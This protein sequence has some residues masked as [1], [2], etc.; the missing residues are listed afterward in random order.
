L[1][2]NQG[3]LDAAADQPQSFKTHLVWLIK[4]EELASPSSGRFRVVHSNSLNKSRL[5]IVPRLPD[6]YFEIP[7]EDPLAQPR[8]FMGQFLILFLAEIH[9][10]FFTYKCLYEARKLHRPIINPDTGA[11]SSVSFA[12]GPVVHFPQ[13]ALFGNDSQTQ[14]LVIKRGD[15][16]A[17]KQHGA[18]NCPSTEDGQDPIDYTRSFGWLGHASEGWIPKFTMCASF[19][20]GRSVCD[21]L[22]ETGMVPGTK[23]CSPHDTVLHLVLY[24]PDCT[25][26]QSKTMPFETYYHEYMFNHLVFLLTLELFQSSWEDPSPEFGHVFLGQLAL[27]AIE[28]MLPSC[29]CEC[30]VSFMVAPCHNGTNQTWVGHRLL[31]SDCFEI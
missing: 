20:L 21:I 14:T 18:F 12:T 24:G 8:R 17:W 13:V 19:R 3:Q 30:V 1:F 6:H 22:R 29:G 4:K 11:V 31:D 25:S 9:D 16:A 7:D 2:I 15:S 10:F 27:V 26:K 5:N 23:S 28:L